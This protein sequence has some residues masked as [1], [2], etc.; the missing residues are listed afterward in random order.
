MNDPSRPSSTHPPGRGAPGAAG[1]AF[2]LGLLL[3]GLACGI[4]GSLQSVDAAIDEF[5]ARLS[6]EEY[7]T[8]Y[9]EADDAFRKT[10]S[11]QD[12]VEFFQVVHTK[13]GEVKKTVRVSFNVNFG[14]LGKAITVVHSTRFEHGTARETFVWRARG[15]GVI[16]VGYNITSRD[17]LK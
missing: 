2:C 1:V 16:L 13:L 12:M 17:L 10:G 8:I 3:S 6:N 14:P 11:E 9:A 4:A 15:D 5:H 7:G